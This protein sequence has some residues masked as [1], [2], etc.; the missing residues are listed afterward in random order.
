[1]ILDFGFSCFQ[2][3]STC[4]TMSFMTLW[5][6]ISRHDA[7]KASILPTELHL[8]PIPRLHN[9][10]SLAAMANEK[11][12]PHENDH[13]NQHSACKAW[14]GPVT[15]QPSQWKLKPTGNQSYGQAGVTCSLCFLF[16]APCFTPAFGILGPHSKASMWAQ[17]TLAKGICPQERWPSWKRVILCMPSPGGTK[18]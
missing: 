7:C 15:E 13:E 5:G 4:S 6:A 1:M 17:L 18:R 11:S 16:P 10:L 14:P 8:H 12:Y 9:C 3:P 2:S